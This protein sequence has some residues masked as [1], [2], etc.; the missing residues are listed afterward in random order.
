MEGYTIREV[1]RTVGLPLSVIRRFV[2]EGFVA[3]ARGRRREYRFGFRDLVV[4]RMAKALAETQVSSRRIGRALRRLRNKLPTAMPLT[5]LRIAA[6][7]SD[8]VV[9]ER[10]SQW[11]ADDGQYLLAFDVSQDNGALTFR[12]SIQPAQDWFAQAFALEELSPAEAIAYY[13]KALEVDPCLA[14]AYANLGRMLHEVGRL[15]EAGRVYAQGDAACD[16]DAVLLYNFALLRE[17]QRRPDEAARLYRRA[18]AADP[19]MG[20]AH[21]NLALLYQ[22]TGRAQDAVRHLSAYRK[23]SR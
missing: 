23:L 15:D 18:I 22:A 7:G 13:R 21:Y 8:V 19:S 10:E 3:P 11:R 16:E 6:V 14:G 5:G 9:C 1:Q 4:L 2:S 12:P 20:D 17:D